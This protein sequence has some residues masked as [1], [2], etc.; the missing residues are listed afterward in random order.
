MKSEK[1]YNTKQKESLLSLFKRNPGRCFTSKEIIA[2]ENIGMGEATA[3]V[4]G[5]LCAKAELTF[6]IGD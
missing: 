1:Q 3:T 4:N 2:D 5:K 6:A